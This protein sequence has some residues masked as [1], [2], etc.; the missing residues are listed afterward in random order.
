VLAE[1]GSR[2]AG[3]LRIGA[4]G[5]WFALPGGGRVALERPAWSRLLVGLARRRLERPAEGL[6]TDELF[7]HGWPDERALQHAARNRVW[8]ALAK[9]RGLGLEPLIVRRGGRYLLD[10]AVEVRIEPG[11]S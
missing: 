7:A 10:P 8:V 6:T 1:A 2:A 3:A 4:D 9:L 5:R 11:A